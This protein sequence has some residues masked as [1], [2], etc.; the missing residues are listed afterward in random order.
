MCMGY[1]GLV[2]ESRQLG[3]RQGEYQALI[4]T[5]DYIWNTLHG[6]NKQMSTSGELVH[7][8]CRNVFV[9]MSVNCERCYGNK[10]LTEAFAIFFS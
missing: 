6:N 10:G 8:T 9:K 7:E 1:K 5:T 4:S 3:C 2:L